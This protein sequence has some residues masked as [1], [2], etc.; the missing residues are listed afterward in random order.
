MTYKELLA[1]L[2]D[3]KQYGEEEIKKFL[4]YELKLISYSHK[5]EYFEDSDFEVIFEAF[6][7]FKKDEISTEKVFNILTIFKIP[8]DKETILSKHKLTDGEGV[9]KKAFMKII[10]REY[11]KIVSLDP[12]V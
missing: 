12:N 5:V 2:I 4:I 3:E 6:D 1:K 11:Q 9:N 8:F 7:I 10:K